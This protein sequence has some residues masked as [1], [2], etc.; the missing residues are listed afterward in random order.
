MVGLGGGWKKVVPHI[1]YRLCR[2]FNVAWV[3]TNLDFSWSGIPHNHRQC[4]S[5][6]SLKGT[7]Q[8]S[9][10][11]RPGSGLD[12]PYMGPTL[13]HTNFAL[14]E[15]G[16]ASTS[17]FGL[18]MEWDSTQSQES[19]F[20]EKDPIRVLDLCYR[21]LLHGYNPNLTLLYPLS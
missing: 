10:S 9:R 8:V 17:G 7:Q 16:L 12:F 2:P 20:T 15:N 19:R 18:L 14:G 6:D 11:G 3:K 4:S 13:A 1:G 5:P 21:S